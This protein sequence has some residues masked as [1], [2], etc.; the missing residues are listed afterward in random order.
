MAVTPV[1]QNRPQPQAQ[2]EAPQAPAQKS[3]GGGEAVATAR[4][5][6]GPD[7]A[8][9]AQYA[10]D[11]FD[12]GTANQ[13]N[14]AQATNGADA[15]DQ[16]TDSFT[17]A[18][19]GLVKALTSVVELVKSILPP[20]TGA[21]QGTG[22]NP[23]QATAGGGDAPITR[24]MLDA[25]G[26]GPGVAPGDP[27]DP[28]RTPF[29]LGPQGPGVQGTQP[30]AYGVAGINQNDPNLDGDSPAYT[31]GSTNCA[32]T[33]MAEIARGHALE[34]PNYALSYK[35]ANGVEQSKKVSEM[36]NEELVNVMKDIG[37]T[38]K[39]GTSPNGVIDMASVL[40]ENVTD[41]EV[42][43]DHNFEPGKPSTS[44]DQKWLDNKLENGEK[45]VVNGAYEAK[46]DQG[47]TG[48]V[49]HFMTIAGKNADG[50]YKVMDPWDGKQK[51]LTG[52]EVRRFM[53]ANEVNGGVMLAIGHTPA[54]HAADAAKNAAQ[55]TQV[56]A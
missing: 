4:A 3:G 9:Q 45:V 51:D 54:E 22:Q 10:R 17:K 29:G 5:S 38:N 19:D 36:T 50:T 49:G 41:G 21:A 37:K 39:E 26:G 35:D 12:P 44:F 24:D 40:G 32:P 1:G 14:Q 15:V 42:Q 46:D 6:A 34:D 16:E 2:M 31:T 18:L 43:Y 23:E 7:Q 48:L 33:A 20:E 47:N 52:D 8:I 27:T 53:Q 56:V 28:G 30:G 25:R 11:C 55:P 13:A